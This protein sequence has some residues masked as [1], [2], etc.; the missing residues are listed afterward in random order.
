VS[1]YLRANQAPEDEDLPLTPIFACPEG[2]VLVWLAYLIMVILMTTIAATGAARVHQ[3]LVMRP[4]LRAEVS[5]RNGFPACL[6]LGVQ[7]LSPVRSGVS[8]AAAGFLK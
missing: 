3:V 6:S 2:D 4:G 7:S 1:C 8:V 5:R